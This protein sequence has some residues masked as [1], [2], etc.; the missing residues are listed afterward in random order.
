MLLGEHN[1]EIV[2][3]VEMKKKKRKRNRRD[4]NEVMWRASVDSIPHLERN[5]HRIQEDRL[6]SHRP[7][8]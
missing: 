4:M 7:G 5:F 8:Y 3:E 6:E 2:N 1:V